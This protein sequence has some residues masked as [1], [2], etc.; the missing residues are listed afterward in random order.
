MTTQLH[1]GTIKL[2]RPEEGFGIIRPRNRHEGDVFFLKSQLKDGDK[3][4]PGSPVE[5]TVVRG[6]PKG[7][8]SGDRAGSLIL[9]G[10]VR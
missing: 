9:D 2:F 4:I 1:R 5:Y 3:P 10:S 6:K 8:R 7:R